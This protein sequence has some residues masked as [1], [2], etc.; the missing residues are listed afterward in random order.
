VAGANAALK[1]HRRQPFILARGESY[2]GVLIDDLVTKGTEEPYRMFTSR[3]EDRLSLRHDNADQRLTAKAYTTGLVSL[4]QYNRFQE[5]M[6]LLEQ[7]RAITLATKVQGFPL[8]QLLKRPN[9]TVK[10]LPPELLAHIPGSLWE[11][12]ETDF[13]YEGYL[14]RQSEHNH[15]LARKVNQRIPDELDYGK[16][17]GLRSETR[18]K[19]STIR[20]TSIGQAARISGITPADIA[21]I[22]IWLS[23]R[24]LSNGTAMLKGP[25]P[26]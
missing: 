5:K 1:I 10:N 3:A 14:V 13:K 21:I 4:T 20:P 6:Q 2:I 15:N 26:S 25:S 16:I 8:S 11:L 9:F 12:V 7:A 19:L 17:V 24:G 23:Q 22:S 18:Q